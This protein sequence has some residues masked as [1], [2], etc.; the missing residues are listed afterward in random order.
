MGLLARAGRRL[1]ELLTGEPSS[2][3]APVRPART[4]VPAAARQRPGPEVLPGGVVRLPSGECRLFLRQTNA[5]T[6]RTREEFLDWLEA[7]RRAIEALPGNA[8][9]VPAPV[10]TPWEDIRRGRGGPV[11]FALWSPSGDVPRLREVAARLRRHLA[12]AAGC[13]TVVLQGDDALATSAAWRP[14]P[15]GGSL[16][17]RHWWNDEEWEFDWRPGRAA[18][19]RVTAGAV[20]NGGRITVHEAPRRGLGPPHRARL[21]DRGR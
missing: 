20:Q 10:G 4:A 9:P 21:P 13:S 14:V 6:A 8:E 18:V 19:T 12:T 3:L 7:F 17:W 11:R 5:L 16:L 15:P 1:G 2:A